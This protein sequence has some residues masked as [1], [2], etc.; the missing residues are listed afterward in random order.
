MGIC[1]QS[2]EEV[3]K[4]VAQ[5]R[6]IEAAKGVIR[7]GVEAVKTV[8]IK[9]AKKKKSFPLS[10]FSIDP[11]ADCNGDIYLLIEDDD[12]EHYHWFALYASIGMPG[13]GVWP[14][15]HITTHSHNVGCD[16]RVLG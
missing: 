2:E 12:H 8:L 1:Q 7:E 6:D 4:I 10:D 14:H 15:N 3:R 16:C 5:F 13:K 11:N 9:L